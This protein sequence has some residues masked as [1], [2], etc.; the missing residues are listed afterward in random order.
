[1]A[2]VSGPTISGALLSPQSPSPLFYVIPSINS[3]YFLERLPEFSFLFFLCF[4]SFGSCQRGEKSKWKKRIS[5]LLRSTAVSAD[6]QSEYGGGR[7]QRGN[8][9]SDNKPSIVTLVSCDLYMFHRRWHVQYSNE[10]MHV[11]IHFPND[12]FFFSLISCKV[13]L[14]NYLVRGLVLVIMM[15]DDEE[16][17]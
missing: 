9:V 11:L 2:I 4:V 1:M 14:L 10:F 13:T 17:R 8:S 16:R 3:G 6:L 5:V 15:A 7:V 12:V